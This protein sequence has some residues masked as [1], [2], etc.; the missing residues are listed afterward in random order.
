MKITIQLV[1]LSIIPTFGSTVWRPA[2]NAL[3]SASW[4]TFSFESALPGESGS[5]GLAQAMTGELV[6]T[7]DLTSET[8][9]AYDKPPGG[10]NSNPDTYYFHNGGATWTATVGLSSEVSHVRVSYALLGF[11]GSA[12]E[13]YSTASDIAGATLINSGSYTTA[14]T[15]VFVSDFQLEVTASN[16]TTT[17]GVTAIGQSFRSI[18]SV[19]LEFF[20]AAPI[21]EPSAFLLSSL[22]SLALLRRRRV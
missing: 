13:A 3:A 2:G 19:Q 17:F 18:D 5:H 15:Q 10:F 1:A 9:S 12:P 16:V 20:N 8:I 6:T 7:S 4:D 22:A 21:P 11:G 14:T